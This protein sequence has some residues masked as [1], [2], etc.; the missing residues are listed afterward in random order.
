MLI[1]TRID[2]QVDKIVARKNPNDW[3]EE[4]RYE[5]SRPYCIFPNPCTALAHESGRWI[6][7]RSVERD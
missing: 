7:D 6:S 2:P 5:P 4:R 1:Y 3:I